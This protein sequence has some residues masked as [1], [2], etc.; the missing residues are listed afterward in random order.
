MTDA[1][2]QQADDLRKW[3]RQHNTAFSS[4]IAQYAKATSA[5][6][7][8]GL[9]QTAANHA[10]VLAELRVRLTQLESI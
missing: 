6:L 5:P 2:L 8:V 7:R 9:L 3:I 10:T 1:E 4:A